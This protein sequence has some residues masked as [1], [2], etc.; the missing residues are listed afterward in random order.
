MHGYRRAPAVLAVV[1]SVIIVACFVVLA[2]Y[3]LLHNTLP[4]LSSVNVGG[5]VA[6]PWSQIAGGVMLAVAVMLVVALIA[7]V[8]RQDCISF[9]NPDGE[10]I[11]AITAIEEF[12]KRLARSFV[13]VRDISPTVVAVDGGVAIEARVA[14][15]DDQNIHAACER[16][17]K[18]IRGQVQQFFGLANVHTVK[19]FIAKTVSRGDQGP[20]A[21]GAAPGMP[22]E[23]Y[24][25]EQA[26][27]PEGEHREG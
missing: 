13:E 1:M 22:V 3:L 26:G 11:I 17:Q 20:R 21:A 7:R 24:P 15:W 27:E 2:L 19:V 14:L 23:E 5:L 8:R 10:V 18:A 16:I 12:I 25:D 4:F 6:S 9:D